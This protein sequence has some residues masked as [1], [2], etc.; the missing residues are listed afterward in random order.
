[1][2]THSSLKCRWHLMHMKLLQSMFLISQARDSSLSLTLTEPLSSSAVLQKNRAA[3]IIQTHWRSHRIRVGTTH[4]LIL[5][6]H[7][8]CRLFISSLFF[9]SFSQDLV[10]LQ[11][12]LRG[13]LIR[14]RSQADPR[15][16]PAA[17]VTICGLLMGCFIIRSSFMHNMLLLCLSL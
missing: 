1:M 11:S 12:C 9:Y 13:H 7:S 14:Q 6:T 17:M 2:Y 16:V 8:E 15:T 5:Y 4:R 3:K 10:L